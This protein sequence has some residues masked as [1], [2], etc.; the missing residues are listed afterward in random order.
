MNSGRGYELMKAIARAGVIT[1]RDGIQRRPDGHH[2]IEFTITKDD[3]REINEEM[4]RRG[5]E[6]V[7]DIL[8]DVPLRV[9]DGPS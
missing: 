4:A 8:Y 3:L 2:G 5:Q 1:S 6:P 9:I 7:G